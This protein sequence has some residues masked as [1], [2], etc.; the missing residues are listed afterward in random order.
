MAQTN[1]LNVSGAPHDKDIHKL[2]DKQE[3][4]TTKYVYRT[5]SMLE[6]AIPKD[7]QDNLA[8]LFDKGWEPI[9]CDH[10]GLTMVFTLR[11]PKDEWNNMYKD[12]Y[13]E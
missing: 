3:P 11:M 1:H 8:R 9:F 4:G 2:L 13:K 5:V 7:G 12:K 10:V 6:S